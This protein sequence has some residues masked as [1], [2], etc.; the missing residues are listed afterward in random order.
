[1]R[2]AGTTFNAEF[3]D[4]LK[5]PTSPQKLCVPQRGLGLAARYHR[6]AITIFHGLI[7]LSN[8]KGRKSTFQGIFILGLRLHEVLQLSLYRN[9]LPFSTSSSHVVPP[10]GKSKQVVVEFEK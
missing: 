4:T 9:Y 3:S 10:L 8:I 7:N 6:I 1:M 2:E 5:Q